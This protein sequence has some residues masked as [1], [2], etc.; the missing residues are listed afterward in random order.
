M[1][2]R[3]Q[4]TYLANSIHDTVALALGHVTASQR[5][6]CL[7]DNVET[8]RRGHDPSIFVQDSV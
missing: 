2:P 6:A 7:P 5:S 1:E 3:H 4:L 8:H